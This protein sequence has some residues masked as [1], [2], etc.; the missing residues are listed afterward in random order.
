MCDAEGI[1]IACLLMSYVHGFK[2]E[3]TVLPSIDDSMIRV[4]IEKYNILSYK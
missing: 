3:L 4:S 2:R 1:M